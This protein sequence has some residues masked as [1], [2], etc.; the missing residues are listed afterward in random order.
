M[1]N[2]LRELLARW[3]TLEPGESIELTFQP[4]ST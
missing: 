4:V 1:W 3:K 2:T